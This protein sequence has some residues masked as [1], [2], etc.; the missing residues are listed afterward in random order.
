MGDCTEYGCWGRR[1][2]NVLIP[3][4]C[5]VCPMIDGWLFWTNYAYVV[6]MDGTTRIKCIQWFIYGLEHAVCSYGYYSGTKGSFQVKWTLVPIQ[7]N[8]GTLVATCKLL[9]MSTRCYRI[10]MIIDTCNKEDVALF[11]RHPRMVIVYNCIRKLTTIT[12][13]FRY[14]RHFISLSH[15]SFYKHGTGK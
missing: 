3:T 12:R 7:F 13:N 10:E 8:A 11:A 1:K 9:T 5:H 14:Y 6:S 15:L 4:Q 2:I